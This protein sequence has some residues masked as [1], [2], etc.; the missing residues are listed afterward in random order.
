[1]GPSLAVPALRS[2]S[3]PLVLQEEQRALSW[4]RGT[5]LSIGGGASPI[6]PHTGTAVAWQLLTSL[7][8]L[9]RRTRLGVLSTSPHG[10]SGAAPAAGAPSQPGRPSP[11]GSTQPT[12][13]SSSWS[14]WGWKESNASLPPFPYAHP[15]PPDQQPCPRGAVS[16]K[17]PR[18]GVSCPGKGSPRPLQPS[19][20]PGV[21]ARLGPLSPLPCRALAPCQAVP[22]LHGSSRVQGRPGRRCGG[23]ERGRGDEERF[24]QPRLKLSPGRRACSSESRLCPPLPT[25]GPVPCVGMVRSLGAGGWPWGQGRFGHS[26]HPCSRTRGEL[27]QSQAA[28]PASPWWEQAENI[29]GDQRTRGQGRGSPRGTRDPRWCLNHS[30]AEG[31][32]PSV[33]HSPPP[34]QGQPHKRPHARHGRARP[35]RRW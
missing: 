17:L 8:S 29:P 33:P 28:P 25:A 18:T 21:G 23:G 20:P 31:Q 22:P 15:T 26:P 5:R 30:Q 11:S 7:V 9:S 10:S 19:D 24:P 3:R 32:N 35:T 34:P 14:G 6:Q 13:R 1:M 12:G 2:C 27:G 4:G 16:P